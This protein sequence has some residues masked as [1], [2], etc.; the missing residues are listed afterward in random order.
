[1]SDVAGKESAE[2]CG[3][4]SRMGRQDALLASI[5]M[6]ALKGGSVSENYMREVLADPAHVLLIA[7]DGDKPVGFLIGHEMPRFDREQPMFCLYEVGV[8]EDAQRRGH[9]G[10]L[11]RAFLDICIARR[12]M[13]AWVLTNRGNLPAMQLY[14]T[15]GGLPSGEDDIECFTWPL[16]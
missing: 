2:R 11:V 5:A 8:S 7:F 6:G 9:G 15:C 1:M 12:A 3:T 4:V 16:S 14:P 13:K 10:R